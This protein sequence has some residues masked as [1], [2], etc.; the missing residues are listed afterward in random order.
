MENAITSFKGKYHFLSNFATCPIEYNGEIYASVEHA[1]QAAKT[2]D[3]EDRKK[4][5][6]APTAA[7]A[8][9]LG[10][11]V[12]KRPGWD[13]LKD[14]LMY[15]FVGQKFCFLSFRKKLIETGDAKLIEGNWWGDTYWGQCPIG[16]GQNKLGEILMDLREVINLEEHFKQE[17]KTKSH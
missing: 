17:T 16:T 11:K 15:T 13:D 3:K 5:Q 6:L 4:I 1:Y 8:K 2:L 9:K 12:I 14:F 10:Q 7:Q